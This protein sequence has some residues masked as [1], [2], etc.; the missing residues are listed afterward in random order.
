MSVHQVDPAM[1]SNGVGYQMRGGYL[2]TVQDEAW[3]RS[4]A[5]QLLE[6]YASTDPERFVD[7][8]AQAVPD[9]GDSPETAAAKVRLLARMHRMWIFARL[10]AL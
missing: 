9:A 2:E 5:G 4:V 3:R 1:M 7:M 8:A 10:W 6:F